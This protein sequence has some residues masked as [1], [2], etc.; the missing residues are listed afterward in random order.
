VRYSKELKA[1]VLQRMMAPGNEAVGVLAKE[2]NVTEVALYAW[3][4][5]V[6]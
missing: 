2:F 3:R 6:P 5:G 4:R 1:T